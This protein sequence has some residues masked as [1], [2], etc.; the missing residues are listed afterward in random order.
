MATHLCTRPGNP[1]DRVSISPCR[2]F[3]RFRL[4]HFHFTSY[5]TH[6]HI[7]IK[8]ELK[9]LTFFSLGESRLESGYT[10]VQAV[11]KGTCTRV[12]LLLTVLQLYCRL[13]LSSA[14]VG[15]RPLRGCVAAVFEAVKEGHI[16]RN[17]KRL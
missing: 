6:T 17:P 1:M 13:R 10:D 5:N 14:A 4:S 9:N 8:E 3:A 7:Y 12:P 16:L 15:P 2:I 11:F